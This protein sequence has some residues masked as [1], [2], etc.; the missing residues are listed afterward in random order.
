MISKLKSHVCQP[1]W[2][3][4]DR[5]ENRRV[6]SGTVQDLHFQHA[7][8][9]WAAVMTQRG[10]DLINCFCLILDRFKHMYMSVVYQ[11]GAL[12]WK[13]TCHLGCIWFEISQVHFYSFR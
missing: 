10:T 13:C 12:A 9:Q 1:H 2:I 11:T 3:A 7:A 5:G 6:P 4:E 8:A